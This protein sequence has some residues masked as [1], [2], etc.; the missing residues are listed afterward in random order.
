MSG[1]YDGGNGDQ[2][3]QQPYFVPDYSNNNNNNISNSNNNNNEGIPFNINEQL[4]TSAAGMF[5]QQ[6]AQPHLNTVHNMT[7]QLNGK[8]K[9]YFNVRLNNSDSVP[10]CV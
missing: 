6:Y 7:Q 3:Q 10:L 5:T 1:F 4:L 2:M 9:Y 8:L